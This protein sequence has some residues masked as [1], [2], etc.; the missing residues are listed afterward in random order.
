MAK[1]RVLVADDSVVMRRMLAT[2]LG[3]E[4]DMEVVAVVPNGK[5]AIARMAQVCP[6]AV[7]LDVEM[8]ELD[9]LATLTELRASYPRLPIVMFSSHTE[10]GAA[11]T[12]DALNRGASDYVT[13]PS[14]SGSLSQSLGI[15]R[16]E[17][18]PRLRAL[19]ESARASQ[20]VDLPR[21]TAAR[22]TGGVDVVVIA[23][24]T[25]GPNALARLLP[26][27][28][29]NIDVPILIVQH[30][31]PIFTRLLAER[32]DAQ[33]H[34]EV[35]EAIHGGPVV[36]GKVWIAPGDHHMEVERVGLA[37]QIKLHR[38]PPES[39]CRPAADPLFRSV[40]RFYGPS[41]LAVVL[42]GMG[43]DGLRGCERIVEAGGSVI[44]QDRATSVVWGMPSFVVNG[45]L[46]SAVLPLDDIPGE[47][48]RRVTS[49]T[50]AH[51]VRGA[52]Q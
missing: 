41:V 28:A 30:M 52:G 17:L 7:V 4:P 39:S 33:T 8:P 26:K 2:V 16:R 11:T 38:G 10:R 12:L 22:P 23:S 43:Q 49:P 44:A 37:M 50:R 6:D 19:V 20:A 14:A 51:R 13:K 42:T 29:K 47:I 46:A 40:A 5:L 3:E 1:T 35:A 9:G 27:L 34:L 18:A 24:S 31:P 45:G 15:V 21:V 48:E 32:L 36:P 25:G